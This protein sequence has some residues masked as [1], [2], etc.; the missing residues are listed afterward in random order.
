M[1]GR[2]WE[3]VHMAYPQRGKKEACRQG[4]LQ[5][6]R[7]ACMDFPLSIELEIAACVV[8][9]DILYHPPEGDAV[10]G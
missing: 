6:S 8:I 7:H 3:R 4:F 5:P 1:A 10:V 2:T 9:G